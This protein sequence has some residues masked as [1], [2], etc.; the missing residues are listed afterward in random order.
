[1]PVTDPPKSS[2]T[3]VLV[4][5]LAGA[6]GILLAYVVTHSDGQALEPV[7]YMGDRLED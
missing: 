5:I 7:D 1:M 2:W 4:A 6:A 3:P